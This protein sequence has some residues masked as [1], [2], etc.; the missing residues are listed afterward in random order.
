M[1]AT[2]PFYR[3][4]YLANRGK[5]IYEYSYDYQR[6]YLSSEV[7]STIKFVGSTAETFEQ[8][9]LPTEWKIRSSIKHG[10]ASISSEN[11]LI[12]TEEQRAVADTLWGQG[13]EPFVFNTVTQLSGD[14]VFDM[15]VNEI[16]AEIDDLKITMT[17]MTM[18]GHADVSGKGAAQFNL[19]SLVLEDMNGEGSANLTGVKGSVDGVNDGHFWLGTQN[20]SIDQIKFDDMSDGF[21]VEK[22]TFSLNNSKDEA[23]NKLNHTNSWTFATV[24]SLGETLVSNGKLDFALNGLD[25]D[26]LVKLTELFQGYES[27]DFMIDDQDVALAL[28]LLLS[29]GIEKVGID[30]SVNFQGSDISLQS[31]LNL[32]EGIARVSDNPMALLD[33]IS[34]NIDVAAGKQLVDMYA[35]MAGGQFEMWLNQGII[36]DGGDQYEA[37]VT[38]GEGNITFADG[39]QVPLAALAMMGLM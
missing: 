13:V 18:E 31:A 7:I 3:H 9:E 8:D 35:M 39:T 22:V 20:M 29:K 24:D 17:P 15:I 37:K 32:P 28:D 16:D 33:V 5:T 10:L 14:T 2:C 11:V 27:P 26:A 21:N 38:I 34:G 23:T 36:V 30:S 25:Y 1:K 19:N 4:W 6:G 12:L